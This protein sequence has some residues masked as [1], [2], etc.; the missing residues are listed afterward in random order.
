MN[1][2]CNWFLAEL[3][4]CAKIK[5]EKASHVIHMCYIGIVFT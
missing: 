1:I 5:E 2:K 4:K 3:V